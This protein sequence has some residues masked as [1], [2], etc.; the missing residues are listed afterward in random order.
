MHL[1]PEIDGAESSSQPARTRILGPGPFQLDAEHEPATRG[2]SG[3]TQR[4]TVDNDHGRA[5]ARRA[6]SST[7]D[8]ATGEGLRSASPAS[9]PSLGY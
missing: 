6:T 4:L 9:A 7:V 3:V 8:T 1:H 2:N 5:A